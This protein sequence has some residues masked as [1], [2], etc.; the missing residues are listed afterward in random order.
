MDEILRTSVDK[1]WNLPM[2]ATSSGKAG[3]AVKIPMLEAVLMIRAGV[4]LLRV[5]GQTLV[6]TPGSNT[7]LPVVCM[8]MR[9][10]AEE[11]RKTTNSW[12]PVPVDCSAR[13]V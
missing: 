4:T 2:P 11:P 10:D 3:V 1:V 7:M 9:S 12:S 6:V 5:L 8:R 13:T